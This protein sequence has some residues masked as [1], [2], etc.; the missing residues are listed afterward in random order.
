MDV[1]S[2]GIGQFILVFCVVLR[3]VCTSRGTQFLNTC[4]EIEYLREMVI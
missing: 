4:I 1:I 2:F 3:L